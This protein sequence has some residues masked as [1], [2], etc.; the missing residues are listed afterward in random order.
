MDN[1]LVVADNELIVIKQL[2]V[3]EERL[4]SIKAEIEAKTAGVLALECNEGTVKAIKLL[5][6]DL[7]KDFDML[8]EERKNVKNKIL[9][10]NNAFEKVYKECVTNV[11]KTADDELKKRIDEVE[12]EIKARKRKEI[13]SYFDEYRTSRNIDFIK[14]ADAGINITKTASIKSLK[15]TAKAFIDRVCDDLALIDTQEYKTEILV[16]Y[17]KSLNVSSSITSVCERHKAIEAERER[18]ERAARLKEEQQA[19]V[20]KVTE[21]AA[22]LTPPKV[23]AKPTIAAKKTAAKDLIISTAFGI[24][25]SMLKAKMLKQII[26]RFIAENDD[27]ELVSAKVIK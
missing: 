5:R 10:P 25:G 6:T 22:P 20:R 24:Q 8:D 23:V 27:I 2:P 13:E 3:I 9:E 17:K 11:Y 12:N 4:K 16:E 21:T 19:A 18:A 26:M 1:E 7:K 15:E 14:F